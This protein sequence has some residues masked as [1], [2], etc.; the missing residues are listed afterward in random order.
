[1]VEK[2]RCLKANTSIY[3]GIKCS[4]YDVNK[5][6][7][8]NTKHKINQKHLRKSKKFVQISQGH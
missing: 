7:K 8:Q 5:Q 2:S 6:H 1:M 4:L 3:I